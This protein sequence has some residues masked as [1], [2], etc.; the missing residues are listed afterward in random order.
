[1]SDD[2]V[3]DSRADWR[4]S[5]GKKPPIMGKQQT[6][7]SYMEDVAKWASRKEVSDEKCGALMLTRGLSKC[8]RLMDL[9]KKLPRNKLRHSDGLRFLFGLL[10]KVRR[11]AELVKYSRKE[12]AYMEEF[13]AK[14]RK[15]GRMG[16]SR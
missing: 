15:S 5:D 11:F 7:R 6:I 3:N 14:R 16:L 8:P 1:M 9:G 12:G 10:Q 4:G 2:A 13:E